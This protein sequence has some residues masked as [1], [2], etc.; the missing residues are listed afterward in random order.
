MD[1]TATPMFDCFNSAPDFTPFDAVTNS[2]PLDEMNRREKNSRR[3]I[4]PGRAGFRQSALD[5][6]DQC[7]K[8]VQPHPLARDERLTDALSGLSGDI[9]Q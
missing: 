9:S 3:A 4:A 6:E 5:K 8:R 2:V 1:A 7:R